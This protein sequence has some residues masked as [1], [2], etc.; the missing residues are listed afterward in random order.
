[1]E[2]LAES[3][4]LYIEGR[5][6]EAIMYFKGS[7]RRLACVGE[8]RSPPY[9]AYI[10]PEEKF[11]IVIGTRI[12][13]Y[14]LIEPYEEYSLGRK[15][16]HWVETTEIDYYK[17][18]DEVTTSYIAVTLIDGEKKKYDVNTLEEIKEDK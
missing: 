13:K 17:Q 9:D 1:M 2:I 4:N 10:D 11:C 14:Y 7:K 15:S 16:S 18:I 3:K 5:G 8:F 6:E 12:I